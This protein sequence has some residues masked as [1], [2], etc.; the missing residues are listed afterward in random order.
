MVAVSGLN[1]LT[2]AGMVA[3]SR[4]EVSQIGPRLLLVRTTRLRIAAV[5]VTTLVAFVSGCDSSRGDPDPTTA[6]SGPYDTTAE[7]KP[8]LIT[9]Q[10]S[11]VQAGDSVS[12]FFPDERM[13][14]I[15]FVLESGTG[16][17]WNLVYHLVSDWG[18]GR[19]PRNYPAGSM[20]GFAVESVGIS[21]GGPDVVLIPPE[22]AAGAYRICTGNSRPNICALLTVQ[23]GA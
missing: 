22:A 15:H 4:S 6:T 20:E 18:A 17:G 21:G 19:E 10:P 12:V 11:S 8:E 16:D 14:G 13:R 1:E 23:P 3:L 9:V 7:I 2:P 5:G